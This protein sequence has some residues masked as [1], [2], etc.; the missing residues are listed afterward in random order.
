MKKHVDDEQDIKIKT[1]QNGVYL[2]WLTLVKFLAQLVVVLVTGAGIY[3]ALKFAYIDEKVEVNRIA[4]EKLRKD[5]VT[6]RDYGKWIK[7]DKF[8]NIN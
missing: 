8:T 5:T 6:W 2:S 3:V 7:T 1:Y 4:I